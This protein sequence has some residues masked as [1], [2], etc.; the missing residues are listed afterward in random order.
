MPPS[1]G[2]ALYYGSERKFVRPFRS[3]AEM[4]EL[5][6]MG[7]IYVLLRGSGSGVNLFR[8]YMLIIANQSIPG[9]H[10]ALSE[11]KLMSISALK[12]WW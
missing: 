10:T 12:Q 9:A 5:K 3:S 7:P 6:E 4:D 11:E 2:H 8:L 1:L